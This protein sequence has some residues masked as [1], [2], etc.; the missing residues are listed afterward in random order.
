MV[1]LVSV[2]ADTIESP[3]HNAEYNYT[4]ILINISSENATSIYYMV[5]SENISY[6][7]PVDYNFSENENTLIAF[8]EYDN[9]TN[10]SVSIFNVSLPVACES[11]WVLND[12]W[13]A[14][15]DYTRTKNYVATETCGEVNDTLITQYCDETAPVFESYTPNVT[16]SV[17]LNGANL[18]DQSYNILYYYFTGYDYSLIDHCS[19]SLGPYKGP[20][21]LE[22]MLDYYTHGYSYS[23]YIYS[24]LQNHTYNATYNLS[25]ECEDEYQNTGFQEFTNINFEYYECI[26][27][28]VL[29]G[30]WS[31]CQSDNYQYKNYYDEFSCGNIVPNPENKSCDYC[32]PNWVLNDTWSACEDYSR[33]QNYYDNNSCGERFNDT[34]VTDVCD[35]TAPELEFIYFDNLV[36]SSRTIQITSQNITNGSYYP[37]N[38][39]LGVSEF[40]NVS[41]CQIIYD[42]ASL[43]YLDTFDYFRDNYE[44]RGTINIPL[45]NHTYTASHNINISCNDTF[46]NVND[47]SVFNLTIEY[48]A[49]VPRWVLNDTWSKCVDYNQSMNYIDENSCGEVNDDL[50]TQSC[51]VTNPLF[52]YYNNNTDSTV[53]INGANVSDDD[54]WNTYY[55]F[56]LEEYHGIETCYFDW[57]GNRIFERNYSDKIIGHDYYFSGTL[58][59]TYGN[60]NV[61]VSH[62][63][64]TTCVDS[65]DNMVSLTHTYDFEYYECIPSWVEVMPSGCG[66]SYWNDTYSCG[67]NLNKPTEITNISCEAP[68]FTFIDYN[69]DVFYFEDSNMSADLFVNYNVSSENDIL[70]CSLTFDDESIAISDFVSEIQLNYLWA[71]LVLNETNNQT[72]EARIKC[73]DEYGTIGLSPIQ[74]IT[75]LYQGPTDD[76]C[77]PDWNVTLYSDCQTDDTKSTIFIEDLNQC[78][79]QTRLMSDVNDGN[80]SEFDLYCDYDGNGLIG[81]ESSFVILIGNNSNLTSTFNEALNVSFVSNNETVLEFEFDFANE[82]LNLEELDIE[83]SNSSDS[84]GF[85]RITGL[86][87]SDQNTTKTVYMDHISGNR[88]CI[89]DAEVLSV[90]EITSGCTGANEISLT[91]DGSSSNGYTCTPD[92]SRYKIEGLKHSAVRE[93]TYTVPP[94]VIPP[95]NNGGGGSGG[96]GGSGN[97]GSS[98]GSGAPIGTDSINMFFSGIP[99][100]EYVYRSVNKAE[101]FVTNVGLYSEFDVTTFTMR[102]EAVDEVDNETLIPEYDVTSFVKVGFSN[103][104]TALINEIRLEFEANKTDSEFGLIGYD[105]EW[106][107]YD[108]ERFA[109]DDNLNYYYATVPPMSYYALVKKEVFVEIID[110]SAQHTFDPEYVSDF[111]ILMD[112]LANDRLTGDVVSMY[113]NID[114]A[115]KMKYSGAILMLTMICAMFIFI[116]SK[117]RED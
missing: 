77:T 53:I 26:S 62:I 23:G 90:S 37:M 38:Y 55:S 99:A 73:V 58:N 49:C 33:F 14:C 92:G 4:T 44:S 29:D 35:V 65:Y 114:T 115:S 74:N 63:L 111:D 15:V 19:A 18:T 50:E 36:H 48:D 59:I 97:R 52:T 32:T 66:I 108:T 84:Y 56:I 22:G 31:E 85:V 96:S 116:R 72:H 110:D 6:S 113:Q 94:V 67:T 75:Y 30:N 93:Y 105:S 41:S 1:L 34:L 82:T 45:E 81:N 2:F 107:F 76:Y 60:I 3:S 88:V 25:V 51:D 21:I 8:F 86:D 64:R 69:Y 16:Q 17:I 117:L 100:G 11:N 13:S 42:D 102:L 101:I 24:S 47:F 40:S 43:A 5:G 54:Y 95:P 46:A 57:R 28:W 89:L 109:F 12:T 10:S 68:D 106:H 71:E 79:D 78:Y 103:I 27:N 91:C 112:A 9:F 70:N 87:L 61:N 20:L 80:F 98:G 104:N 83:V 7:E 39:Y